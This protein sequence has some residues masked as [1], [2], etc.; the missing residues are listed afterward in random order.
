[1]RASPCSLLR[2][3]PAGVQAQ[4]VSNALAALCKQRRFTVG[5]HMVPHRW[6]PRKRQTGA[7][8]LDFIIMWCRAGDKLVTSRLACNTNAADLFGYSGVPEVLCVLHQRPMSG[9]QQA[10]LDHRQG[11]WRLPCATSAEN[12]E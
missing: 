12:D 11:T 3:H 6:P 4:K 1:M 10:L 2:D 9:H 7:W 5:K 8:Q